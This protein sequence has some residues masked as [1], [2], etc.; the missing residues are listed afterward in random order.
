MYVAKLSFKSTDWYLRYVLLKFAP[1]PDFR[2]LSK[3]GK[4]SA[5]FGRSPKAPRRIYLQ[6]KKMACLHVFEKVTFSVLLLA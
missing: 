2:I 3:L 5:S 6:L 1:W 4:K